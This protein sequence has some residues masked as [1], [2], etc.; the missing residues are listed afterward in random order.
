MNRFKTV[1]LKKQS[2][3]NFI[4]LGIRSKLK[5]LLMRE[6][7]FDEV[8]SDLR[9]INSTKVKFKKLKD[10]SSGDT[11]LIIRFMKCASRSLDSR[12]IELHSSLAVVFDKDCSTPKNERL[13][14]EY[15]L[16]WK[17]GRQN[18]DIYI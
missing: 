13:Y 4:R 18:D 6:K 8:T 9:V 10:K 5:Y 17:Q 14:V 1:K 3:Y 12:L 2:R 7:L 11:F 15:S 16:F